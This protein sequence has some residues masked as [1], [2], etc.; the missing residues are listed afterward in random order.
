M[1]CFNHSETDGVATCNY[2]GR[3]LCSTCIQTPTA[4]RLVCS[5]KC[6]DAL[7]L[8]EKAGEDSPTE[9]SQ[10]TG[11]CFLLLSLCCTVGCCISCCVV[12][13]SLS[14]LNFVYRGLRRGPDSV[15]NLVSSCFE[16]ASRMK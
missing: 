3:A 6:A 4:A 14:L 5:T 12:H 13:A 16:K 8:G 9:H 10:R 15:R 11:K 2:C 7:S 1:K